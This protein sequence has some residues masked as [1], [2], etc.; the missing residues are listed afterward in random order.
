MSERFLNLFHSGNVRIRIIF[1]KVFLV[2][3]KY[4]S[5]RE[6]KTRFYKSSY[7]SS[8]CCVCYILYN[9]VYW[10]TI[11]YFRSYV[12]NKATIHKTLLSFSYIICKMIYFIMILSYETFHFLINYYSLMHIQWVYDVFKKMLIV[13][14]AHL[15]NI[16]H[17]FWIRR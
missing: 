13:C 8:L 16:F 5:R 7:R 4:M 17:I 3:W 6:I 11:S 15:S 14:H 12:V 9:A 2:M 1:I 10:W